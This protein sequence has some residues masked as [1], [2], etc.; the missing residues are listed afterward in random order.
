MGR[1]LFFP[2]TII[3]FLEWGCLNHMSLHI[4]VWEVS[5]MSPTIEERG[6]CFVGCGGGPGGRVWKLGEGSW[7]Q[8]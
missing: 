1:P 2:E 3:I 7:V 5:V 8:A 4:T 6:G